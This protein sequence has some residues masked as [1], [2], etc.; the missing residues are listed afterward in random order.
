MF[1]H[2]KCRR[3]VAGV[4][5]A[6]M[7][8]AAV[9]T[10]P[11]Q[12]ALVGTDRVIE[13]VQGTDRDRVADFL[14]RDDVTAQLENLGVAPEEAQARVAALSDEEVAA[15][16]QRIDTMPAGQSAIGAIIGAGVLIFVIL[17]VTD[18]L[19]L[20]HV[21]GFTQKGSLSPN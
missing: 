4:L 21:F 10:G 11:A 14:A 7:A 8:G 17:L 6:A 3:F 15:I 12:A 19:G 20:T 18:L 1:D 9:A 16:A 5:V 13:E 2:R